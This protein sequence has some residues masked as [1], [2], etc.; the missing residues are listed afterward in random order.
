MLSKLNFRSLNLRV[1]L[2]FKGR[3]GPEGVEVAVGPGD[4]DLDVAV[5]F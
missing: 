4:V 2:F 5:G 3:G 1:K